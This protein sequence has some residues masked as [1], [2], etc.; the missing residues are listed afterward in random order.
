MRS[1]VPALVSSTLIF[2][3]VS[4]RNLGLS[5]LRAISVYLS[6]GRLAVSPA[7]ITLVLAREVATALPGVALLV[8]QV[9]TGNEKS[10]RAYAEWLYLVATVHRG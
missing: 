8:L 1:V 4:C 7:T 3:C 6:A 2:V 5:R 9:M 10:H